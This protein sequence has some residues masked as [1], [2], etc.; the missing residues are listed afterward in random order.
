L[1]LAFYPERPR[2]AKPKTVELDL[3]TK[4]WVAGIPDSNFTSPRELGAILAKTPQC[5][6]CI[7]KQ[8][9]RYTAGRLETA[10]DGPLIHKVT[11]QFR[12]SGYRFKELMVSLLVGRTFSPQRAPWPARSA[13]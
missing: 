10:A 8:Y 5:Q 6:E 4:G 1:K 13:R 11:D 12:T 3:D 7:V 2:N 9:F